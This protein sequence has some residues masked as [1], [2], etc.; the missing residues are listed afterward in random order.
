MLKTIK[1]G[2]NDSPYQHPPIPSMD[3]V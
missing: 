2:S 3:S 1:D